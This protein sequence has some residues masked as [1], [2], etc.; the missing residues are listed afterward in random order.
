MNQLKI[1]EFLK[2]GELATGYISVAELQE[3]IPFDVKRIFW[4]YFTPESV[5]RGRHA[6]YETEMVIVAVAGR[7]VATVE[8][9]GKLD[10]Y[11]L[12]SPTRGLY[13]PSKAWHTLQYS[14][15]AV[16]LVLSSTPYDEK[17]YI[18]DY[19]TFLKIK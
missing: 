6:H 12:D 16:Q 11:I 3:S 9:D 8:L 19:E 13:L 15:N 10:S 1:I 18:R 17:D 2:I 14:H 5:V 4:T 7:I